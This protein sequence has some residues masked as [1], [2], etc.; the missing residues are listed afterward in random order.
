[1]LTAWKHIATFRS[2]SKR[3]NSST[4]ATG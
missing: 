3:V 2:F 1:M 4:V